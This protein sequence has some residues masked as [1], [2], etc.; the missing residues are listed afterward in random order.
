MVKKSV[1]SEGSGAV[2]GTKIRGKFGSVNT[3]KGFESPRK[4]LKEMVVEK[5]QEHVP[6]MGL[7]WENYGAT[8]GELWGKAMIKQG[9]H[10][11]KYQ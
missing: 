11:R 1:V 5:I 2:C 4:D 8:M 7:L 3:V 9:Q 6:T 10:C